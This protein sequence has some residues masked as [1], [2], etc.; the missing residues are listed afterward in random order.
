MILAL[1]FYINLSKPCYTERLKFL[2]GL[3]VAGQKSLLP[4]KNVAKYNGNERRL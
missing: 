4:S 2:I 1:V 3:D